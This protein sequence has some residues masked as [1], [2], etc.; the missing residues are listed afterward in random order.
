MQALWERTFGPVIA[1]FLIGSACYS[2]GLT[3]FSSIQIGVAVPMII[4][5][6]Q[7]KALN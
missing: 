4:Y 7:H 3:E 5:A 1:G 2:N 6:L